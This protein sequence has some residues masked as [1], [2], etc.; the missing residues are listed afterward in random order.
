MFF[1]L[2]ISTA[3]SLDVIIVSELGNKSL[4]AWHSSKDCVGLGSSGIEPAKEEKTLTKDIM[5]T[6]NS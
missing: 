4:T 2:L 1:Q 3:Y 6:R 5:L